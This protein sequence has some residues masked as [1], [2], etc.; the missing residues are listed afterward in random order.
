MRGQIL[1]DLKKA[2]KNQDKERL[3]VIRMV[4]G[5]MQMAEL[6]KKHELT[7]E[8]VIDVISK[9]IKSRKDS[10]LE[11]KK[12]GR[13]DLISKTQSE[14]D[15]LMEYLPKQLSEDE[16]NKIIDEV[17]DE[18]KPTSAKEMGLVMKT[19]NPKVKGKA[20]MGLVSKI[21]KEKISKE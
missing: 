10:I 6:N 4:K 7:D 12:G 20:D 16:L 21:V 2:M 5:S 8:E 18:V 19:L 15:I 11:F 14:I 13:E 17:F 1:E 3:S 9:E